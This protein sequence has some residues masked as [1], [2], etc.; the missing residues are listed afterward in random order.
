M[1]PQSHHQLKDDRGQLVCPDGAP[2]PERIVSLVPSDTY[3]LL[4]L[5]AGRRL[6]GRTAYCVEPAEQVKDLPVV[7]GTKD[8]DV[9][10]ILALRPQ[11]VLANQE[12]N[13]RPIVR[14]LEQRGVRVLVAFPKTVAAGAGHLA[15]LARLLGDPTDEAKAVIAEAYALLRQAEEHAA[16]VERPASAFVPIWMD[17]L[18]TANGDTFLSDALR[19]CGASNVFAA[20]DRRYPL[21]ADR[22]EAAPSPPETV[23][24][25]DTRY[26]RISID[27]LRAAGPEVVLLPDEPHA[28]TEKDAALFRALD[29]PAARLGRIHFCDGKDLLWPGLRALE[30]MHRLRTLIGTLPPSARLS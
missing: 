6:V 13:T 20:R 23:A 7:G 19:L 14:K 3:N 21:A 12:E 29:I 1:P 24:G 27:E 4:R 26:P 22:G 25:R 9:D 15:R 11:V 16:R 18:M 8:A 2:P 30:G 5:G 28:F 17:P 10:A